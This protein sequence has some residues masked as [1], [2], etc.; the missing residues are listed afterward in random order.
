ME[1]P[2]P[3]KA[4]MSAFLAGCSSMLFY[5]LELLKVH[6]IVSD[7]HSKNYMNQFPNSYLALRTLVRN[8]G[9]SALYRGCHLQLIDGIAWGGYFYIY[10]WAKE[11]HTE[12]K[13]A[14]PQIFR[15]VTA[16]EAAVLLKFV[17]SPLHVVKTRVML[18][19]N[20]EGWVRDTLDSSVKVW[21]VDGFKG[22]WRGMVPS[23]LLSLNGTLHLFFYE[24]FKELAT[25]ETNKWKTALAGSLSKCIASFLTYPLQTIKFRIQ[26]EQHSD[27]RLIKSNKILST[28]S[29]SQFFS[30]VVDCAVTT[31]E[32]EGVKGLYRGLT[33]N[34]LRVAPANGLFF[35][36]YELLSHIN[37]SS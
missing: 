14:H 16:S 7:G 37:L 20:S 30:G 1:E 35:V 5:P 27:Q 6:R 34:L 29:S 10:Q 19:K 15:L 4:A 25:T 24:N 2:T 26:Q 36:M 17:L 12:M 8:E 31:V 18:I 32:R 23:L 21:K 33:L 3:K 22:F 9:V 28:P 11:Y 13:D